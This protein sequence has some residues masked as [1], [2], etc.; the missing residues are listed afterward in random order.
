MRVH[1]YSISAERSPLQTCILNQQ[2]GQSKVQ[3][4]GLGGFSVQRSGFI[5]FGFRSPCCGLGVTVRG[6]GS[7]T[8]APQGPVLRLQGTRFRV[9]GLGVFGFW[10]LGAASIWQL[11]TK[12]V[13]KLRLRE[14]RCL[15]SF[16][17]LDPY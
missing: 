11:S 15:L 3:D 14:V 2:T 10:V 7:R 4:L 17:M 12:L 8:N 13:P 6:L 1:K 9:L 5:G 16:T